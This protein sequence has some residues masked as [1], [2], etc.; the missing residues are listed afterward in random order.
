MKPEHKK[1]IFLNNFFSFSNTFQVPNGALTFHQNHILFNVYQVFTEHGI[2]G[3]QNVEISD[4]GQ[5][6]FRNAGSYVK[7]SE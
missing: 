6:S 4:D 2:F 1:I 7:N 5:G 3:F